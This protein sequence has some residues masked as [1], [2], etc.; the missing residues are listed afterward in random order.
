MTQ[1]I[2]EP[3]VNRAL[4]GS[5]W[6][7]NQLYRRPSPDPCPCA[8]QTA[9]ANDSTTGSG[10]GTVATNTLTSIFFDQV[11]IGAGVTAIRQ[12]A[13]GSPGITPLELIADGW[14]LFYL[15]F[16]W[17]GLAYTDVRYYDLKFQFNADNDGNQDISAN[18]SAPFEP[19]FHRT[20]GPLY[21][22]AAS[23]TPHITVK[24][25][26]NSG[27]TETVTGVTFTVVYL[28]PDFDPAAFPPF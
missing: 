5:K 7:E 24:V 21:F 17:S 18:E 3:T 13:T 27:L 12:T 25:W 10:T 15:D 28:G 19:S 22:R 14:W 6:N 8:L 26:H 9:I 20:W 23:L 2:Q 16:D 1:P 11:F 4:A